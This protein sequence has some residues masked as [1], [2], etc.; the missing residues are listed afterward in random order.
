MSDNP[1]FD[2]DER[3]KAILD[4]I[5]NYEEEEVVSVHTVSLYEDVSDGGF[6][7]DEMLSQD[8]NYLERVYFDSLHTADALVNDT[9][10]T[11]TSTV[12]GKTLTDFEKQHFHRYNVTPDRPCTAFFKTESYVTAKEVFEALK[13]EGFAS[14]HVRCLHR[15]PTG[16]IYITFKTQEICDAFL[17]TTKFVSPRAPNTFFVPQNSERPLTFL[18]IYDAPYELSDEALI[19]RLALYC[20]VMWHRRGKFAGT[21]GTVYNGL[22][23]YR[24][25]LNHPI[26][27][28]LRFGKFLVRL[29]Y[30][31][32]VPTCR[33]CNRPDHKAAE[34]RNKICFNCD[35]LGHEARDCIRPMYCCICKSGQHLARDCKFSWHRAAPKTPRRPCPREEIVASE[36]VPADHPS[37]VCT[38]D[39]TPVPASGEVP[40]GGGDSVTLS[41]AP[42]NAPENDSDEKSLPPDVSPPPCSIAFGRKPND[43]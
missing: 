43:A 12:D 37:E 38:P 17:R 16:E 41:N 39:E 14:D 18:T 19:H 9:F 22:R 29:Q 24:V 11:G 23:H 6:S 28:F 15:K 20:E 42:E 2:D 27:S 21:A 40:A 1:L 7:D 25:C 5:N 30:E 8:V 10:S 35:G 4:A 3:T 31:G 26:P 13:S 33:K 34:C 32:Q 36:D